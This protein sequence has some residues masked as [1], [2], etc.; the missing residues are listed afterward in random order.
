MALHTRLGGCAA[1]YASSLPLCHL[2]G[3]GLG[4][5]LGAAALA[6]LVLDAAAVVLG[7]KH[8]WPVRCRCAILWGWRVEDDAQPVFRKRECGWVGYRHGMASWHAWCGTT[9]QGLA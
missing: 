8:M 1:M 2:R 4:A 6:L 7:R 3:P 9:W 5:E